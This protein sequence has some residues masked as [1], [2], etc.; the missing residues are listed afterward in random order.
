VEYIKWRPFSRK[1]KV[2]RREKRRVDEKGGITGKKVRSDEHIGAITDSLEICKAR[3]REGKE[4]GER[5][6]GRFKDYTA[7]IRQGGE[8]NPRTEGGKIGH[9]LLRNEIQCVNSKGRTKTE[10][11]PGKNKKPRRGG[12]KRQYGKMGAWGGEN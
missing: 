8:V 2:F 3:L 11:R 5:V 10:I 9:N 7:L 4:K 1:C 6:L 12:E